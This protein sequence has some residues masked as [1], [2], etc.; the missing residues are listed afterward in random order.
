VAKNWSEIEVKAAVEDYFEMLRLE[1]AGEKYNKTK[2]RRALLNRLDN[3]SDGSVEWKHQNISAV[4][5]EMGIQNIE[6]YKPRFNYQRKLLPKVVFNFLADNRELLSLFKMDS[7]IDPPLPTVG[8]FLAA[9]E[10]PPKQEKKNAHW[11]AESS[12][13]YNPAGVNYIEREAKNQ[14]LGDAGEQFVLN[15]ERARLIHSGKEALAERIEQVSVTVGPSAGFDIRSFESNG[16]DRYIEAKT[17][18]YGKNTPFFITP[19][20]LEFSRNNSDHYFLYRIFKFRADPRMFTLQGHLQD[21]CILKPS[22]Y[23]ARSA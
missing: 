3:R 10:A 6:G 8:D 2:H 16:T 4:L 18:K 14:M 1:L 21:K 5:D 15:Y 9:L 22:Q 23:L 13:I 20:E 17:T 19:N 7:E 12:V 11:I